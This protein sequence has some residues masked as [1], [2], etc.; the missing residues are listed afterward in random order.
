MKLRGVKCSLVERVFLDGAFKT[1]NREKGVPVKICLVHAAILI[2]ALT[3][4]MVSA[5]ATAQSQVPA[6]RDVVSPKVYV[7]SEPAVR[8]VPFQL[9]VVF[10]IR[11]GFHVNAREKSEDYLIATDLRAEIPAGFKAGAVN[12]PKGELH[13]FTFSKKPLNVYQGTVTLRV[14]VTALQSAHLGPQ[15]MPLKLRYQACSTE[16]CLPPVTIDL[17]A[18]VNIAASRS[19]AKP[20]HAEIFQ[21]P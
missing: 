15:E 11:P 17:Q 9:A 16:I 1:A 4:T 14:P 6:P 7:S 21:T 12:Y 5:A 13:T 8:G 3:A 18:S 10:K 2:A 20:A 19:A